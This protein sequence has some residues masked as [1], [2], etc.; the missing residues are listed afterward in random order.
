MVGCFDETEAAFYFAEM[1][2]AIRALH[3]RGFIHRDLKPRNWLIKSDGHLC[4]TDF[5]LSKG[6]VARLADSSTDLGRDPS[7]GVSRPVSRMTRRDRRQL[8]RGLVTPT[9]HIPE[10][11]PATLG[12]AFKAL[13]EPEFACSI[14]GTASYMAPEVALVGWAQ[15]VILDY[16]ESQSSWSS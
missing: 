16:D 1:C 14:V 10:E 15:Q 2:T 6:A 9:L 4:L 11:C 3:S 13:D 12:P 5:G 7:R 8:E